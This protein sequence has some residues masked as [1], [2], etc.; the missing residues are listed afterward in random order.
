MTVQTKSERRWRRRIKVAIVLSAIVL[1][2]VLL[3]KP[4]HD[5]HNRFELGPPRRGQTAAAQL[6]ADRMQILKPDLLVR[7]INPQR[8]SIVLD[9]GAG[10][11][12]FTIPLAHAVGD[13]GRVFATDTDRRALAFVDKLARKDR[14]KNVLTVLVRPNGLDPFYTQ[15]TFDTILMSEVLSSIINPENFLSR[16]RDS[17]REEKGRLWVVEPKLDPDFTIW[18]FGNSKKLFGALRSLG[19]DSL[20]IRRFRSEVRNAL[21]TM[22]STKAVEILATNAIEDLNRMLEDPTLW[23]E[24]VQW[25]E[26]KL[27]SW[28]ESFRRYLSKVVELNVP[29]RGAEGK[30]EGS[31]SIALR[32]LNRLIL[33]DLIGSHRWEKAISLAEIFGDS[34]E[35]EELL[36]HSEAPLGSLQNVKRIYIWM[37]EIITHRET[38]PGLFRRAGYTLVREHSDFPYHYVI[39]FKREQD[40]NHNHNLTQLAP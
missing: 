38:I 4:L 39:E 27:N 35:W 20:V 10:Y 15:H 29:F 8:G 17:L 36:N 25:E 11:G 30:S 2:V 23:Q 37:D 34:S 5:I 13:G 28:E 40:P 1:I 9:L 7:L 19:N 14:L 21:I 33:Q 22:S 3:M 18:E 16:L 12:V 31:P 6:S 26:S 24:V 32:L